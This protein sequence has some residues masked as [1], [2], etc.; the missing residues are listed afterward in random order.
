[1]PWV[2]GLSADELLGLPVRL[3]GI[4]LG[5]PVDLIVDPAAWR[6]VGFDVLCGDEVHRFLPLA[7]VRLTGEELAV[8]SALMLLEEDELAFYRKRGSTFRA[9]RGASV[10]VGRKRTGALR[11]LVLGDDGAVAQV[12]VDG[13]DGE[14]RIPADAMVTV[15]ASQ[16]SAA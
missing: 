16:R 2:R 6:V 14:R 15:D 1:M 13:P 9:L 4:Q 7:A 5:R 3:H 10:S 12:V 11:S 8:R